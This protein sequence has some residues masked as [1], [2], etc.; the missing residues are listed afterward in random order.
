MIYTAAFDA[1]PADAKDAVY[2]RL[3]HVLSGADPDPRYALLPRGDRQAIVEIL[4]DTKSD[5]PGYFGGRQPVAADA[6]RGRGSRDESAAGMTPDRALE[7]TRQRDA[8]AAVD[9]RRQPAAPRPRRPTRQWDASSKAP[10]TP[11]ARAMARR[12]RNGRRCAAVAARMVRRGSTR[13]GEPDGAQR[14][15][16]F[17]SR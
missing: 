17:S 16:S 10:A 2:R 4:R 14:E 3:W 6:Q 11:N 8:G 12:D 7:L 9:A 15:R 13:E 1:L 5:L